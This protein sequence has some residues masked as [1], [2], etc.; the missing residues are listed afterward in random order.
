MLTPRTHVL[1]ISLL[2]VFACKSPTRR[3]EASGLQSLLLRAEEMRR[4]GSTDAAAYER[5]VLDLE[6]L[7]S[8]DTGLC[9]ET[10]ARERAAAELAEY[11]TLQCEVRITEPRENLYPVTGFASPLRLVAECPAQAPF[12]FEADSRTMA[13]NGESMRFAGGYLDARIRV[14]SANAD[15][16]KN[17]VQLTAHYYARDFAARLAETCS[18][19]APA[20]ITV[21]PAQYRIQTSPVAVANAY[22]AY[23]RN[24]RRAE[25]ESTAEDGETRSEVAVSSSGQ[26]TIGGAFRGRRFDLLYGHP[27]GE[28]PDGIGTTFTTVRVDGTDFRLEQQTLRRQRRDDAALLAEA[29]LARTGITVTQIVRPEKAGDRVRIRIA[30]EVHNA[31]KKQRKVGIRLLL[32]TWA[33]KN[34]GV[35]FVLPA[36]GLEQLVRTER[37]VSPAQALLWHTFDPAETGDA[38]ARPALEGFLAGEGLTPPD[39]LAIVNWPN[40]VDTV[41]DYATH[42]ERRITG[43]SAAAYWWYPAT[44]LPGQTLQ[45]ATEVGALVLPR[46]PAVFVTDAASGDLLVYLWHHNASE[47]PERVDYTVRAEQGSFAFKTELAEANLQPGGIY[48]RAVPTQI[49]ADGESTVVIRETV[50]GSA[51]EYRFPIKGLRR[52]KQL[53]FPVV[54][55]AEA[56]LPVSYFDERELEL[57]ARLR[58]PEG[59]LLGQTPLLRTKIAGGYEY[60]GT[61]KLP[62]GIAHGR[63][64]VE[65]VR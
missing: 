58:N 18:L 9:A 20:G 27:N 44:V 45:I 4:S 17:V 60:T 56:P 35:P 37:D 34:D 31:G 3:E 28:L 50:N 14:D 41:W 11:K 46:Q 10:A 55:T 39:R 64:S 6:N 29:R 62:A 57:T 16:T 49:L 25:S 48:A 61:L 36:A 30:Y 7:R 53:A 42:E 5:L 26:F 59:T 33:G 51:R 63:Y 54:A 15:P 8:R 12:A 22:E 43:D 19:A 47:A 24:F 38:G 40:A 32:D 65:V 13:L 2:T 21:L 1:F 23:R 52:W